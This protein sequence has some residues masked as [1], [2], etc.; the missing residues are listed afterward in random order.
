LGAPAQLTKAQVA[1]IKSDNS[2]APSDV[3]V[4]KIGSDGKYEQLI[5]LRENEVALVALKPKK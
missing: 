3:R 4:V 5:D 2:G 1:K